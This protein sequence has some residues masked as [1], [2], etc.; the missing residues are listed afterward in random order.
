MT[1]TCYF[2]MFLFHFYWVWGFFLLWNCHKVLL[3]VDFLSHYFLSFVSLSFSNSL[4]LPAVTKAPWTF[5]FRVCIIMQQWLSHH[6]KMTKSKACS[7][8][9]IFSETNN[10]SFHLIKTQALSLDYCTGFHQSWCSSLC[11]L[12]FGF[13]MKKVL[14][15]IRMFSY[16]WTVLAQHWGVFCFSSCPISV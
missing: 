3:F 9:R 2:L 11:G 5:S 6:V 8:C 4:L 14:L 15:A 13:V 16:C 7:V 1:L 12:C 10:N